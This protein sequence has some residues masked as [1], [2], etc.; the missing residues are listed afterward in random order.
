MAHKWFARRIWGHGVEEVCEI[1][2]WRAWIQSEQELFW[3]FRFIFV[4]FRGCFM[5]DFVTFERPWS[6][7][8][9]GQEVPINRVSA[10]PNPLGGRLGNP[11]LGAV[12]GSIY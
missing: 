2:S 12:I 6:Y 3:H 4:H 9:E 1:S 11:Y 8:R 5:R 10:L 7:F